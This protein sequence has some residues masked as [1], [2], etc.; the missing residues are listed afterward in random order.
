MIQTLPHTANVL[1]RHWR[2]R[3]QSK[4]VKVESTDFVTSITKPQG[5]VIGRNTHVSVK[6]IWH[7]D[8]CDG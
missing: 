6:V 3:Q 1:Q 7:G 8:V 5:I 2:I 4:I